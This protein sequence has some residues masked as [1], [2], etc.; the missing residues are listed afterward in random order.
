MSCCRGTKCS[1]SLARKR[2]TGDADKVLAALSTTK[3]QV[4]D[5]TRGALAW[6]GPRANQALK[7][8]EPR[9]RAAWKAGVQAAAP[10]VEDAARALS[11]KIDIARDKL[12]SAVLPT[13]VEAVNHAA[14]VAASRA[15]AL[16]PEPPRKRR[17]LRKL[18][19]WA[20]AFGVLGWAVRAAARS[21]RP[22]IDPWS[23]DEWE[24]DT[25]TPVSWEAT[26]DDETTRAAART[27]WSNAAG[28]A[29]DAVG[30]ATGVAVRKV[31]DAAQKAADATQRAGE[32]MADA[33]QRAGGMMADATQ[34]AGGK[35][36]DAAKRAT[37]RTRKTAPAP[38]DTDDDE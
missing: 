20:L 3:A 12:Q 29:A 33:T 13:V 32:K 23:E 11:P 1:V 16:E 2:T 26:D 4:S 36:A 28:D 19:A 10:K 31:S 21:Q 7:W 18:L 5:V 9:A 14:A 37:S 22:T 17:R 6:A 35:V 27:D 25:L 34:R 8:A 30:E 38:E 24:A 15:V